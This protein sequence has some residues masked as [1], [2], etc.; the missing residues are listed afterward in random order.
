MIL[1][2]QV[3]VLLKVIRLSSVP[4]PPTVLMMDLGCTSVFASQDT[5]DISAC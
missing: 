5:M 1:A 4:S 3:C 2:H